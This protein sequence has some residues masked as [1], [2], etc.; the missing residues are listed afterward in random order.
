MR[1]TEYKGPRELQMWLLPLAGADV[2][3]VGRPALHES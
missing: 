2:W 3:V 1:N